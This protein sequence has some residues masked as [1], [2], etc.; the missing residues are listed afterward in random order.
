LTA[1][2]LQFTAAALLEPACLL[3]VY[4]HVHVSALFTG[5]AAPLDLMHMYGIT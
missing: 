2:L 3:V 1:A 5:A 4:A